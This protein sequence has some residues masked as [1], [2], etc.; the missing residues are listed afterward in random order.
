MNQVVAR[1][2]AA[3]A[4]AT[5]NRLWHALRKHRVSYLML[6]PF[7]IVFL[8][9][10]VV[11]VAVSIILS[12]YYYNVFQP[13][14]FI[15]LSN[16]ARLFLEDDVFIIAIQNTFVF[17]VVTGPVSFLAAFLLAW[18]INELTPKVRILFTIVFYAPSI[19]SGIAISVI[20]RAIF[21]GDRYGML[22][23][24]LIKLGVTA[25]PYQWLKDVDTIMPV[26]ILVSLWMSLGTGFLAFIAGLQNIPD[27]IYEAGDIDGI[28]NRWQ[29]LWHLTIPQMKPQLMFGAILQVV[30]SL[31]VFDISLALAGFPS[32]LYAGETILTHLYDYGFVRFDFGYSSSIAVVLF[33]GMIGLNQI[34]LRVFSEKER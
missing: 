12:L 11:P 5:N 20:W 6:L 9:F 25:T 30:A 24:F 23:N 28:R 7:M 21:A 8:T 26:L 2:A 29:R 1:T 34:L 19:T 32:P 17:A 16:Y 3:R 22:N 18:L 31:N 13:P 14:R 27:D 33:C 10:I 4:P 15:G